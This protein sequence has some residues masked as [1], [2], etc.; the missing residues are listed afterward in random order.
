[1]NI[2]KKLQAL[3][4]ECFTSLPTPM[5]RLERLSQVLGGPE[6]WIKHED[7]AGPAGGGNKARKLEFILAQ[8]KSEGCDTLITAGVLQSNQ[9]RQAAGIAAKA[10]MRAE[11]VLSQPRRDMGPDYE[12]NGNV[13]LCRL[14][15]ANIHLVPSDCD[16]E[17]FMEELAEDLQAK[18]HAPFIVPVGA[19]NVL[20]TLGIVDCA[21]EINDQAKEK[22]VSFDFLVLPTGSG[23]TQAGMVVGFNVTKSQTKV[24]GVDVLANCE[25]AV[26]RI[27]KLIHETCYFLGM[28]DPIPDN[29][30]VVKGEYAGE[31]A[32]IPTSEMEAA[33]RLAAHTEGLLLDP[34][35]TGKAMAA[36]IDLTKKGYFRPEH[37]VVFLHT[38][39]IEALYAYK[40]LFE[41]G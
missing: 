25:R 24:I 38:G 3:P 34:V 16:R 37:K 22:K 5:E 4:R 26:Q 41:K 9:A 11:I 39:G 35:Y 28:Q 15:G 31:A 7:V 33:V 1:M 12:T 29:E 14:L 2:R 27:H 21:L 20:G 40:Y 13:L 17:K 36:V 18:G 23:G 10:G 8:A 30:V 6:I 19:S 32:G